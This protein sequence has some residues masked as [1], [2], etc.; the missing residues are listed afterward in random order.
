[1]KSGDFVQPGTLIAELD[2]IDLELQRDLANIA[3][4]GAQRRIDRLGQIFRFELDEAQLRLEIEQTQLDALRRNPET[5]QSSIQIQERR[6][7]LAELAINRIQEGLLSGSMIDS[8]WAEGDAAFERA[9][10]EVK[11][12]ERSLAKAQLTAP[13]T[14]T[15][16]FGDDLAEGKLVQSFTPLANIVD[17]GEL[18]IASNLARSDLEPFYEE[19]PVAIRF[20]FRPGVEFT[21]KIKSLP[22]PF[23]NGSGA[24]T[25]I[26]VDQPPEEITLREGNSMQITAEIARNE[27]ALWL[28]PAAIQRDG[29]KT[30]VWVRGGEGL[31]EQSVIIGLQDDERIEIVSGLYEGQEVFLR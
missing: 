4:G 3:L 10:L 21:G 31:N 20:K 24:L 7:D 6:V 15:V 8:A 27:N 25:L 14:G 11:R 2:T 22:Q 18:I 30:F 26:S 5:N 13:F 9:Q 29:N 19:M 17:T 1:V 23:G 28:P 16:R 12:A